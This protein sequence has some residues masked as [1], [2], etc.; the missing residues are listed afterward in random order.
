MCYK[1]SMDH[2]TQATDTVIRTGAIA[3]LQTLAEF[4]L[5]MFE[6]AGIRRDSDMASGWRGRFCDYLAERIE[7][8]EAQFFVALDNTE[9][10]GTSAAIVAAAIPYFVTGIKRGY[11]FGVRVAPAHR[12]R[13]IARRLTQEAI[14]FLWQCGCDKIR[15]HAAPLGQ[16]IYERL[17]FR[18]TN[19]MELAPPE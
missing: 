14:A 18:S 1:D 3:E 4:W 17:G 10:V 19:E 6:E 16:R 9:I 11:I 15:L 8:G 13:G 7:A 12:R 2:R 5:A